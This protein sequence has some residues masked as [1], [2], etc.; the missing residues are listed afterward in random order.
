MTIESI[1]NKQLEIL[2]LLYRFRFLNRI[3]IQKLLNHKNHS[4]ITPWL[5][6]LTDKNIITRIYSPTLG[7]I[8]KP[9]IY[10]LANK[11]RQI[12]KENKNCNP[13]IL[14]RVYREKHRSATFRDHWLFMA[15]LYFDLQTAAQYQNSICHFYTA[16][17]LSNVAYAP[18]PFPDAY[19]TI[20]DGKKHTKRYFLDV[21]DATLP[22]FAIKKRI[23]QYCK[24]YQAN[25]WQDHQKHPFPK[26]LLVCPTE[27]VRKSLQRLIPTILEQ[28]ECE[29]SFFFSLRSDIQE[30]GIQTDTWKM[31]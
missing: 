30:R 9:A 1:T 17:D 28:E 6:D 8:N 21:L 31:A 25:Y 29:I 23:Y 15:D 12:L 18:L 14:S 24:Y 3:H 11:S 27:R 20:T 22:M 19:L 5:K 10:Y 26:I 2:I 13:D 7:E 4:R 16:T